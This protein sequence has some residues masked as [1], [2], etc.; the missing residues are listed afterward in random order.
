M[1]TE[2]KWIAVSVVILLVIVSFSGC[3]SR[4][5]E[6]LNVYHAGSLSVP[7]DEIENEFEEANP[8]VDVRREG[9]GSVATVK[10]VTEQGKEPDVVGVA[11]YSLIPDLMYE[12][13]KSSWTI[14]FA[15]NRMVIAYTEQ[16]AHKEDIN[17]SN[18]YEVLKRDEVKFGFSNPNDDPCGYRS[19]MVT[20]LA[21]DHYEED[22]IFEKLI[23]ENTDISASGNTISVP[24]DLNVNTE[25][26]MVRSSEVDLMSALEAGEIDYLFIYQSVAEQHEGVEFIQLPP[27]IDLSSVEYAE[28]YGEVTL[29]RHTGETSIGK[30][31][32]YGVTI[33]STAQN[34]DLAIEFVKFLLSA[35][36]QDIM[37]SNGQ[38][39]ID[40]PKVDN[41]DKIPERLKDSVEK[42]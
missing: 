29:T 23:E 10:K 9:G 20:I 16:S 31:I 18:W 19:Q 25:K 1:F 24:K 26:V 4:Q 36:G 40:P 33:P 41:I 27:Q 2:K 30:P 15:K 34:K 38:P 8:E 5:E 12:G 35:E 13:D 32:V 17:G 37:E 11:D 21:E 39:P 6:V 14:R 28:N 22:Q 42:R 7:F 3:V